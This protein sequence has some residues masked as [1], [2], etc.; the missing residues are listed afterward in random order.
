MGY[1]GYVVATC[2]F[3]FG[4]YRYCVGLTLNFLGLGVVVNNSIRY[5]DGTKFCTLYLPSTRRS[6][7]VISLTDPAGRD[8]AGDLAEIV[9]NWNLGVPMTVLRAMEALGVD[10]VPDELNVTVLQGGKLT[11]FTSQTPHAATL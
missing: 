2:A 8:Y 11:N 3:L 10:P 9:S 6:V 7:V 1:R 5:W 4:V